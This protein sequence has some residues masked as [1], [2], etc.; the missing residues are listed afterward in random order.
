[1]PVVDAM[2]MSVV[3]AVSMGDAM[4]MVD[5]MPVSMVDAVSL[6]DAVSIVNGTFVPMVGAISA[7]SRSP[8][9]CP[10]T[11]VSLGAVEHCIPHTL[12]PSLAVTWT[13]RLHPCDVAP[14]GF[15]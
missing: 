6:G 4:S 5:T 1:M 8:G 11:Q 10:W 9:Q 7:H 15:W 3:D 2:S 12:T 14:R 13:N